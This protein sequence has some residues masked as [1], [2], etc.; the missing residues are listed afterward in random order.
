MIGNNNEFRPYAQ[1]TRQEFFA[2]KNLVAPWA[3]SAIK[4]IVSNEISV[5]QGKDGKIYM[6]PDAMITRQEVAALLIRVDIA[7][8]VI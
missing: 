8:K 7:E 5:G 2:D 3:V 4:K 1:I 6:N